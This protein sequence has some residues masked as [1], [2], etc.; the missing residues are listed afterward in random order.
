MLDK[1]PQ[2]SVAFEKINEL[3]KQNTLNSIIC[4][5]PFVKIAFLLKLI[6]EE[7]KPIL[8]LDFDLL[9]SGY[10][11]SGIYPLQ[12][13][14]SLFQPDNEQIDNM[15]K[16]IL[17]NIS[18]NQ[19]VIVIDS[20]NGLSNLYDGKDA[21]RKINALIML[22]VSASRMNNSNVIVTSMSK[23]KENE[24]WILTPTGRHLINS[25]FMTRILLKQ[26]SFQIIANHLDKENST[27]ESIKL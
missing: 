9:F 7:K 15:L 13:N 10:T 12:E 4:E 22:L 2:Q 20:F 25:E 24:G 5:E 17:E 26:D 1:N 14:V 16:V 6:G 27:I 3:M 8:Y 21:A 18:K 11:N 23:L 19:C